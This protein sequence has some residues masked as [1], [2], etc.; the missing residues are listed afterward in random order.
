[1]DN[2]TVRNKLIRSQSQIDLSS[3]TSK[4]LLNSTMF[5]STMMSIQSDTQNYDH[6]YS[7]DLRREINDIKEK[8]KIANNEIDNLNCENTKLMQVTQDQQRQI[9]LLKKITCT[10]PQRK[11]ISSPISKRILSMRVNSPRH[12]P[13]RLAR[14]SYPY[15]NSPSPRSIQHDNIDCIKAVQSENQP[16]NVDKKV[17]RKL[18]CAMSTPPVVSQNNKHKVI[19]LGDGQGR[20][21]RTILQNL[22]GSEYDVV[23][24]IKP[25][26]ALSKI[27]EY[28]NTEISTLTKS[29]Y[30]VILGGCCDKNPLDIDINLH[31]WLSSTANT[32]V[33]ISEVPSN[34]FLNESKI[35]YLLRF[36]CKKYKNVLFMDMNYAR[37]SSG[38]RNHVLNLA[39]SLL[40][41]ILFIYLFIYL[42]IL[43]KAYRLMIIIIT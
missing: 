19:I 31:R 10:T 2:I 14:S 20:G 12:S 41:E 8:L 16:C 27:L 37:F 36:I 17:C 13:L 40:K 21:L 11:I 23:S 9:E 4:D 5:D 42:F 28:S 34:R 39:R 26:A 7:E 15:Y 25:G 24:Y 43:R 6:S 30:V 29:D 1:M 22:L 32:N 38:R 18:H 35:N 33:I 3:S